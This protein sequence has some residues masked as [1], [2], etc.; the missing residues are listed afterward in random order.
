MK[1]GQLVDVLREYLLCC[2]I[3]GK[4]P[5]TIAWY[6]QKLEYF[7]E[8]LR[9][10]DHSR[11]MVEIRTPD[12][13]SFINHL[14]TEVMADANNPCKPER[15]QRLSP[16]TVAGYVRTLKAFFSWAI[17]EGL[18]SDNPAARVSVPKTPSLMMRSFSED[19]LSA[20]LGEIDLSRPT[21]PRDY[22]ILVLLL[23]TGIRASELVGLRLYDLHLEEGWFKVFGKGGKERLI[24]TGYSCQRAVWRYV[25]RLRPE[26]RIATIDSVFLTRGGRPL[27]AHPLY[28][29]VSDA[30]KRAG[31]K[32]KRLGPHSCRHTYARK[33]L[34]N[35][36]D[37]LTLQRILGHSS[38][39]VVKL[40]VALTTDDILRKQRRFSP[41]DRMLVRA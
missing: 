1:E 18:I 4:S 41:M 37:L 28:E 25:K 3:E 31:I 23:D 40:Y 34:M 33:F 6:R 2:R 16:H 32:G 20:L 35:G 22:A 21:G 30:C 27:T 14:Q 12:L 38:L 26:P 10:D 11:R 13:R 24:P 9:R 29:I 36:G 15:N 19:E 39:D 8:F 5:R 17:R 7:D